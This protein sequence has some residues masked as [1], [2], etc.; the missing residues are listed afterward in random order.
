MKMTRR[1]FIRTASLGTMALSAVGCAGFRGK[2]AQPPNILF[3][4]TDDQRW[5]A[6][7][8]MGNP[9]IQTPNMDQLAA[10]GTL[11]TN[12]FV[13]TSICCVSRAS[14]LSGQYARRHGIK[15]F[16]A[17]FSEDAL[18]QTYPALLRANGYYTGFIGKW[19]IGD[20]Q[21]KT[22]QGAAIFDY[23]AGGAHQTNYW[24]EADCPYVLHNGIDDKTNNVCTCPADANGRS[25]P[26]TRIG[27]K[28]IKN[29]V[30]LTT[31]IVP[32][33]A[34][35]FLETRDTSKPFCLSMSCKAPHGPFSD[36]D[37]ALADLYDDTD[38]PRPAT[39]TLEEAAKRPEYLRT[40]LGGPTGMNWLKN[41]AAF[42]KQCRDYYRQITGVDIA[43]GKIRD[44][45]DR[46]GLAD[47]TVVIFT[48]DNGHFF[49]EHGFVGKWLMYE[50]SIRVPMIVYDPRKPARQ[51][52]QQCG[53][54]VLN[55]DVAPTIL[56]FAGV[57]VPQGMQ[58]QSMLPLLEEP[59]RPFRDDWFYEHHFSIPPKL[60]I[61]RSEGV[62]AREWKYIRYI[63]QD[64]PAEEL[65][66]LKSDPGET[67]NLAGEPE[68]REVLARLRAR[69][70]EHSE[71]LR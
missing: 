53:E 33:K 44:T 14:A 19:G 48:S 51:R 9:H 37:T 45:L 61:E 23:W 47:N 59:E 63:D 41:D 30:H 60:R 15:D 54:M 56:H 32:D 42:Q 50:E 71:E 13:T 17:G 4:F 1:E 64:P 52:G 6:V 36:W 26:Q 70:R 40:S 3:V 24:H 28:D 25:G 11:F 35:Q 7:G 27:R 69:W 46:L 5:D 20:S 65:Y 57:P 62:R 10:D 21:K 58:G 12:G 38:F 2:A 49:G 31:T 39:A 43:L 29:A 18:S 34:A 68:C 22:D 66:D 8:C 16:Y 67:R 55:I